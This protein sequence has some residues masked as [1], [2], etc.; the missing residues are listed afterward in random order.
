[1][2]FMEANNPDIGLMCVMPVG[3]PEVSTCDITVFECQQ[4][5]KGD[6]SAWN[7]PF[8]RLYALFAVPAGVKLIWDMHGQTSVLEASNIEVNA[9][10]ALVEPRT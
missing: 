4:V 2:I 5:R 6:R 8:W 9:H 1:M 7:T 10:I 3:M